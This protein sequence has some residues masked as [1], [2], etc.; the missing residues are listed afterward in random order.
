MYRRYLLLW[1]VIDK[2]LSNK[3]CIHLTILAF[4]F[5]NTDYSIKVLLSTM[6]NLQPAKLLVEVKVNEETANFLL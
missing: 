2:Y 6:I 1:W 3:N 5:L 4:D